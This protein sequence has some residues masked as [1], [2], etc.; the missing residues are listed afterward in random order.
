ML[1]VVCTYILLCVVAFA[2][3]PEHIPENTKQRT[4]IFDKE[5]KHPCDDDNI[6]KVVEELLNDV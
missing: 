1:Y 6:E 5:K 3:M 2:V 4:T